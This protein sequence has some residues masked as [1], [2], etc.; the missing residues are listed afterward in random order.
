[1]CCRSGAAPAA[2]GALPPLQC[3][4]AGA[5]SCSGQSAKTAGMQSEEEKCGVAWGRIGAAPAAEEDMPRLRFQ[6]VGSRLVKHGIHLFED[7][8]PLSV[9]NADSKTH[10]GPACRLRPACH[11]PLEWR[12]EL[13]LECRPE[14]RP[15]LQRPELR[16]PS[17]PL[18]CIGRYRH[19]ARP[20]RRKQIM[21]PRCL[22][23]VRQLVTES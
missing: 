10:L 16:H 3:V 5:N 23:S 13:P 9:F 12:P 20:A 7:R 18:L 11:L 1:M 6:A 2:E 22:H 15:E 4:R 19:G 8:T 14:C 17:S 21:K